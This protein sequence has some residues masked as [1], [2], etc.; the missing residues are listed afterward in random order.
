[1]LTKKITE[2]SQ[3]LGLLLQARQQ[4]VT[5]AESCTGGGI[6][7]A[8]T[9]VSGSS[10]WFKC[11][12]VTYSNEAKHQMVNV[13]WKTLEAYG[14]VSEAVVLEMAK[15]ALDMAKAD[16]A[17]AVSGIAGP[18]GGS[19]EKSVGTVC[20]AWVSHTHFWVET[21]VF[22]GNRQTVRQKAIAHALEKLTASLQE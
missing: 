21:C 17:I 16:W 13:S 9:E 5:T 22:E 20:F 1:M 4:T 7:F 11:T 19:E 3:E 2:L 8:L 12:F 10:A 15:G 14:A 18:S 6:S